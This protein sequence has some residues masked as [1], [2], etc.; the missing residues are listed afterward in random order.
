MA[1]FALAILVAGH[2]SRTAPLL[3]AAGVLLVLGTVDD[4]RDVSPAVRVAA[5]FT[6][7]A[8]LAIDGLGW[9]LGSGP[10]LDAVVTGIWVVGVVNAFNLF[11][12]MDG[13]ASTMAAVASAGIAALALTTG[14]VWVAAGAAALCGACLGFLPHNLSS[15]ARIF[16]GDGG[17][18]PIG[19]A[20]AVLAANA[21]RSA[22]PAGLALLVGFL[23]V[24]IPLLDT[25][26]VVVSRTRRGVSI[27]TGGRDHL[28]HLTRSK[29]G[30]PRRV[31]L[32]LGVLQATLSALVILGT[33]AGSSLLVYI[34]LTFF[35]CAAG[36]I[37]ALQ[38]AIV[39]APTF[40]APASGKQAAAVGAQERARRWPRTRWIPDVGLA[41]IGLGAGLS[42]LFS[43]YYS[44]GVWI[45]LGLVLVVAAA[46]ALVARPPRLT[47][48]L[49]L[50][51][52]GLAGIGVW[53]LLSV[54]WSDGAELAGVDANLWLAYAALLL[55][56][57][58][59]LSAGGRA[60]MLLGAAGAGVAIVA[61]IVL[62]RLVAGDFASLFSA[63]R[64]D[65]PLGYVNGEGCVFAMGVWL[66]VSLAERRQA[67]LAGAGAGAAVVMTELA[68]MSQSRG[69]AIATAVTLLAMLALVPGFRRRTI[70]LV[71]IA[72]GTAAAA[73]PV[74]HLYTIGSVRPIPSGVA[75]HAGVAVIASAVVVAV[76]WAA[77]VAAS[78]A[79]DRRSDQTSRLLRRL[80]TVAAI[81]V[82]VAPAVAV[83]VRRS[84]IEHTVRTQWHAFVDVSTTGTAG[85]VPTRL[86]SG[87]GDRY[88]YWRVAWKT[89]SSHPVAGIGA[90]N[91][92]NAYYRYRRTQESIENPHSIE[93][94]MLSE[95]GVVGLG[96]LIVFVAG[97]AVGAVRL[98]RVARTSAGARTT[99]VA[100]TGVELV[101][102]I[103]TSG[104]WMHLLPG[105]TAIALCGA[106]VLCDPRHAPPVASSRPPPRRLHMLIAA[107]AAVLVLAI[108]GASLLRAT[109][110]R[111]Y[112]DRARAELVSDPQ[113]AVAA[114]QQ[115]L[116]VDEENLDAYYVKAAGEARFNLAHD[117]RDTL[118]Q[119][120]RVA[121]QNFVTWTLLGDLETR[122]GHVSA[123]RV[124]YRR[125]LHLDPLDPELAILAV[126][127]V[128]GL[129]Q[130]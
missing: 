27:F 92:P 16:L 127:P 96:L 86:L 70:A 116:H 35:V 5:E 105:V 33:L 52:G 71:F 19:M 4:H 26:L 15:P 60:R 45:V 126:H 106:A 117:A 2:P 18:M 73:R 56:S 43:G 55:L 34:A 81:A 51:F 109:V 42:P 111:H 93:L 53:S 48:S 107:A 125:A 50:S 17:S 29:L 3:L 75:H 14:D 41:M 20:V 110:A 115:A 94:Q 65:L 88:D 40:E 95:L 36:A 89:F 32:V 38:E 119:A 103:D 84:S 118:S 63:G 114:S 85:N 6:I 120:A 98:R 77:T 13:Q 66:A 64:L 57:V 11:D 97:S 87:A 8:L 113:G 80:A 76:A 30:T 99:L 47:L 112:L 124:Y 91:Y 74:L 54:A 83:V 79:L 82:V 122:A 9:T 104:D 128:R 21:A 23:L 22:E 101:W 1:A 121:P 37:I 7:G 130:R 46:T 39:E 69:A 10:A 67:L 24:G 102:L 100:A 44:L 59:L 129:H 49:M 31:A 78:N 62:I 123:A 61:G 90:G 68:L 25:A 12:N 58:I 28:T 108:G 72:A